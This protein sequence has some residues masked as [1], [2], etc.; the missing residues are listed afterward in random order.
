MNTP[1]LLCFEADALLAYSLDPPSMARTKATA[2]RRLEAMQLWKTKN[3]TVKHDGVILYTP[4]NLHRAFIACAGPRE[5]AL[6]RE[7][8]VKIATVLAEVNA[9]PV[10]PPVPRHLYE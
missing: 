3:G 5:R 2:R 7:A 1:E 8:I 6:Q 9:R 4:R 10:P